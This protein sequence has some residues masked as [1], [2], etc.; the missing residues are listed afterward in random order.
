MK[1]SAR[2]VGKRD[3]YHVKDSNV[4]D[5]FLVRSK[6]R[7]HRLLVTFREEDQLFRFHRAVGLRLNPIERRGMMAL[8]ELAW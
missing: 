7:V 4:E 6:G 3:P 8:W 5:I 1:H 2:R